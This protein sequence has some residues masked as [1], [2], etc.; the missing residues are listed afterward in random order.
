MVEE[1]KQRQEENRSR[2]QGSANTRPLDINECL[3]TLQETWAGFDSLVPVEYRCLP[4]LDPKSW[5]VG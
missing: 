2:G 1:N 4:E 5:T 3:R